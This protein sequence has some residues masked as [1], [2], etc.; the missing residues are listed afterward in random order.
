M[1]DEELIN[2]EIH[3]WVTWSNSNSDLIKTSFGGAAF[4]TVCHNTVSL[5]LALPSQAACMET[6][7]HQHTNTQVCIAILVETHN[8]VPVKILFSLTLKPNFKAYPDRNLNPN[9]NQRHLT[10][11]RLL[12]RQII[13]KQVHTHTHNLCYQAVQLWFGEWWQLFNLWAWVVCWVISC[14]TGCCAGQ[15]HTDT[16]P[17]N[18]LLKAFSH[19][20]KGH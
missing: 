16:H 8:L 11:N 17:E 19:S 10:W 5:P 20:K 9:F 4:W 6:L 14:R 13:A 18:E 12:A 1:Y 3:F 7:R 15:Q 2:A